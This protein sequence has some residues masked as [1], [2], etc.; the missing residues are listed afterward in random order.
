MVGQVQI[1]L[2]Q[3]IFLF[4]DNMIVRHFLQK[5]SPARM[6]LAIFLFF[7][8]FSGKAAV[9]ASSSASILYDKARVAYHSLLKSKKRMQ[10]RDQW[11]AVIDKFDSVYSKFSSSGEAYKAVFTIGDLYEQLYSISRRDKDLDEALEYYRLIVSE[12]K[13]GRLTDDALYRQGEIYF[14]RGKYTAALDSY[15]EILQILPSGDVAPKAKVRVAKI[16]PLV[17][18]AFPSSKT[19]A[20][21][22]KI[23]TRSNEKINLSIGNEL[24]LGKIDYTVGS[25]SV[26][27]VTHTSSPVVFS[28][29]RLSNPNRVY[30]NFN[31]TRLANDVNRNI[32]VGSRFLKS[33]RLSQFDE[34][35]SR[36]VF[37]LN[38]VGSLKVGVWQEGSQLIVE[39]SDKGAGTATAQKVVKT[40]KK[41]K[42]KA[43][44]VKPVA[45]KIVK[46]VSVKK[47]RAPAKRVPVRRASR[48]R[49]LKAV[50]KKVPLIVVDAGHG[51]KDLGAQGER[52]LKEKD[53]NLAIALR[54]KDILQSRYKYK[55]ILTRSDDTF[56]PLPG[57]GKIANDNEADVFV[58]VHANA[59]QRHAAHGIETYHLGRGHSEDAKKTAARE[60]GVWIKSESEDGL[61]QEILAS[62]MSS[63]N[64]NDSSWLAIRI[65]TEL[66]QSMRKKYSGIKDLGVKQG[67]FFVLHDTDMPSVLVEVGFV[68]NKKE[69]KRLKQSLY[70][71]RLASS[72][73]KGIV[74]F[75]QEPGPI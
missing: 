13:P 9:G 26:R 64:M 3:A 60:N 43:A 48:E 20:T 8:L 38:K 58:S 49:E 54:L 59:A 21:I 75:V 70:L 29:G 47:E 17:P 63:R 22:R 73:A 11:V 12:F 55:V 41:V 14:N 68:T 71:D 65:Q 28:Q 56:I 74:E 5:F 50:N 2:G 45:K 62:M 57:R 34:S 39:L 44:R 18:V 42:A 52:G 69:E 72:I 36:L 40:Q 7:V 33:L 27:V 24:I 61:V 10:R 25:D 51:G 30:I 6:L 19:P 37:D 67:P 66:Y 32:K 1:Y 46:R 4:S 35:N 15:Q 16:R 31:N 53:V 23:S